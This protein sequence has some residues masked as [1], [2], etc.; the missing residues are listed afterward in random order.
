MDFSPI[1]EALLATGKPPALP[2]CWQ[3]YPP[4]DGFIEL[5]GDSAALRDELLRQFTPEDLIAAGVLTTAG[6]LVDALCSGD[7]AGDKPLAYALRRQADQPPFGLLSNM[8]LLG[9]DSLPMSAMLEDYRV[10]QRLNGELNMVFVACSMQDLAALASV[11][12]PSVPITSLETLG[13]TQL[14]LVCKQLGYRSQPDAEP[15]SHLDEGTATRAY[16]PTTPI[17][18]MLVDW[19]P[20][21]LEQFH[22]PAL[23]VVSAHLV[24][25]RLLLRIDLGEPGSWQPNSP[26]P[27]SRRS[28]TRAALSSCRA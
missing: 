24:K 5:P 17:D 15:E 7:G 9:C 3:G 12:L 16:E 14:D 13:G 11:G 21:R 26:R 27:L 1:Y 2:T 23:Q 22:H 6:E 28:S 19:S 4:S 8:H 25:L 20:A 18:L 10:Q